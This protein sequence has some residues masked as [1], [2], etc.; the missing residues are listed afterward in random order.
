MRSLPGLGIAFA[1]TLFAAPSTAQEIVTLLRQGNLAAGESIIAIDSPLIDGRMIDG[2]RNWLAF[3]RTVSPSTLG[4]TRRLVT[5][6]SV[7]ASVGDV[8]ADPPARI[9]DLVNIAGSPSNLAAIVDL[10]GLA[11]PLPQRARVLLRNGQVVLM[12]GTPLNASGLPPETLC[13]NLYAC[14][15]N[16]RDTVVALV[17][18]G[19]LEYALVRLVF[20]YRGVNVQRTVDLRTWGLLSDGHIVSSI[21]FAGQ[22]A[23]AQSVD[24]SGNWLWRVTATDGRE[25]LV[26]RDRVLLRSGDL[27]PVPGRRIAALGFATP[28]N[29]GLDLNE[30]GGWASVVKLT[31][32]AGTDTLLIKNGTKLAQ[33]GDVLPA[34]APDAL[35]DFDSTCVR[36]SSS[37]HVYWVARTNAGFTTGFSLMRDLDVVLRAVNGNAID[38]HNF[39]ITPDGRYLLARVILNGVRILQRIDLGA[40]VPIPGCGSNPGTL[41]HTAGLMLVGHTV[42]LTLDGPAP[43]GALARIHCSREPAFPGPCGIF[44]P[45][46]EV[47]ID[48]RRLL[49]TLVAGVVTGGAVHLDLALPN[50]PALIGFELFSQ[51]SFRSPAG[52]IRTNGLHLTLGAP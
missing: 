8:L 9:T 39:E 51:G 16:D 36:I 46:G 17:G 23:F 40:S 21:E 19:N 41:R 52:I 32:D 50:D 35:L 15:A 49:T 31:G 27:A 25:R 11:P 43:L 30:F 29:H 45:F 47:L 26:T 37:G 24:E 33:E 13:R 42:R 3:V 22:A 1:L 20:D 5:D 12:T 28:S 18:T 7:L 2:S 44:T 6:G 4:Q 48:R 10:D 34:L 38:D 14:G